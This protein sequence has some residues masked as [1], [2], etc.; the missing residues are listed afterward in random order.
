MYIYVY[1]IYMDVYIY[2]YIYTTYTLIQA[3]ANVN[4]AA[5]HSIADVVQVLTCL[6][7][8]KAQILTYPWLRDNRMRHCAHSSWSL[9]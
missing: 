6:T 1:I 5:P 7:S 2:I 9:N 3:R 8:T 4:Q